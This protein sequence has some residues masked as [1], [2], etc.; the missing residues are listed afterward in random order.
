[1]TPPSK[2]ST[3]APAALAGGVTIA[4][5]LCLAVPTF[6]GGWSPVF[7]HTC[8]LSRLL[9]TENP[10]M[11]PAVL[12]NSP[13]GGTGT[14]MGIVVW[15]SF[16]T[17]WGTSVENG[18]SGLVA[19]TSG[20]SLYQ[21]QNRSGWGPGPN[22]P[23]TSPYG[24]V[25]FPPPANGAGSALIPTVSDLT[26]QGEA[27]DVSVYGNVSNLSSDIYLNNGFVQANAPAVSTC[28]GPGVS[29]QTEASAFTVAVPFEVFGRTLIVPITL[30]FVQRFSYTFPANF[31][32]WQVDNLSA[33]GGPG[34]GWAFSYSPCS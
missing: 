17:G 30:Q 13:Y 18:T 10:R 26:D 31:G 2:M 25:R 12:V 7:H 19:F 21:T 23:C 22:L 32:T 11:L 34:G 3:R 1:M 4:L 28:D 27:S 6:A 14:G 16:K 24:L 33:P 20:L 9:A 8:S 15:P 5:V 29:R